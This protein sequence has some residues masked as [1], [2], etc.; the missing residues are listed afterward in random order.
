MKKRWESYNKFKIAP[1]ICRNQLKFNF[2]FLIRISY[3]VRRVNAA[4][5]IFCHKHLRTAVKSFDTA[6]PCAY[7]FAEL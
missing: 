4:D 1:H 7:N 6:L 2:S 3:K 5:F